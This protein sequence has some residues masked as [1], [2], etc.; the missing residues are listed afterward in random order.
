M[1]HRGVQNGKAMDLKLALWFFPLFRT[2]IVS[3]S[4]FSAL[5]YLKCPPLATPKKPKPP[6]SSKIKLYLII[7]LL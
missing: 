2:I 5:A 1:V 6:L 3:I 7:C 4:K